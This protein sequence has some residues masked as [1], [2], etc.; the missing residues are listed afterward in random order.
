MRAAVT[1]GKE[2]IWLQ[3]H[4]CYTAIVLCWVAL[5]HC[6]ILHRNCDV[7]ALRCRMKV[8]FILTWN[9]VMLR[10]LASESTRYIGT[11]TQLL[12]SMNGPLRHLQDAVC[13]NLWVFMM[14]PR[15][16]TGKGQT[17]FNLDSE[18]LYS[19]TPVDYDVTSAVT[20]T[21]FQLNLYLHIGN[22][23]ILVWYVQ[24]IVTYKNSMFEIILIW[25]TKKM[26]CLMCPGSFS[27]MWYPA[28]YF[29]FSGFIVQNVVLICSNKWVNTAF[30]A[31]G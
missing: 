12:C 18:N 27:P 30:Y 29:I 19:H 21:S 31:R 22:I 26:F 3:V 20:W 7:T 8:K 4:S 16:I 28:F 14:S 17:I 6:T 23:T 9:A 24:T 15:H 11:A 13:S 1:A 5:P 25:P 10:W 2:S